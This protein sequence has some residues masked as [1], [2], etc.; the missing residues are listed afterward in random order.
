MAT[1]SLSGKTGSVTGLT[2][3]VE[4]RKWEATLVTDLL[5]A[6]SFDSEGWRDKIAGLQSVNGS[7]EAIGNKSFAL[8]D[9]TTPATI[10]LNSATGGP[11][12]GGDARLGNIKIVSEAA[13]QVVF[14]AT[15]ESCGVWTQGTAAALAA[16]LKAKRSAK[17]SAPGEAIPK[18]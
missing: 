12:L 14:T 2:D 17:A 6:S 16:K 15:F 9:A 4:I 18:A 5:D 10:Q 3:V 13:G 7:I 8:A 11:S 1:A